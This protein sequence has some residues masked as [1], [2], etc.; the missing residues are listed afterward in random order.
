MEADVLLAVADYLCYEE[1]VAYICG[2]RKEVV[3]YKEE[4]SKLK[5][6]CSMKVKQNNEELLKEV[7]D[8]KKRVD[9]YASFTNKIDQKDGFVVQCPYPCYQRIVLLLDQTTESSNLS[10]I[11]SCQCGREIP[12]AF[13]IVGK[14]SKTPYE[15]LKSGI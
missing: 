2:E 3:D 14:R 13:N 12:V 10:K 8:L 9:E 15:I 5:K 1:L 11:F 6:E 7:E 4:V